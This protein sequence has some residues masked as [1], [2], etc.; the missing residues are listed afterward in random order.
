MLMADVIGQYAVC[1]CNKTSFIVYA[2][3][4]CNIGDPSRTVGSFV[5]VESSSIVNFAA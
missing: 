3:G 4:V 2:C 1:T 5:Y